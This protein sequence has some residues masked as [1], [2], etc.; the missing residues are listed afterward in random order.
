MGSMLY[1]PQ[2]DLCNLYFMSKFKEDIKTGDFNSKQS[3]KIL[4]RLKF[5]LCLLVHI[6]GYKLRE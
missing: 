5:R 3:I 2:W 6:Y 4:S 1:H